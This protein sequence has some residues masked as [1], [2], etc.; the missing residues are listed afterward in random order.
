M[1]YYEQTLKN[2]STSRY[3]FAANSALLLG[4][5]YEERKDFPKAKSYFEKCLSLDNH[6]YQNSLDQKAQAGLD[7]IRRD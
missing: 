2:G 1:E 7:R 4:M 3:Y 6:E 5:I